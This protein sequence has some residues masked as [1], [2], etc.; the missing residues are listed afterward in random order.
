[1]VIREYAQCEE[2][3]Q[4]HVLRIGI[5]AEPDQAHRFACVH[6]GEDMN[7]EL[8]IGTGAIWGTNTRN[9]PPPFSGALEAGVSRPESG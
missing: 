3:E 4:V 8:K 6:C 7:F 9:D 2:C 1:M 5:G